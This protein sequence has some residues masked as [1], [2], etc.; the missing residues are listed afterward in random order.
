[1][2]QERITRRKLLASLGALGR[3][4]AL[5]AA[6]CG[7]SEEEIQKMVEAAVEATRTAPKNM[8]TAEANLA[9]LQA[10]QKTEPQPQAE[11]KITIPPSPIAETQETLTPQVLWIKEVKKSNRAG[12]TAFLMREGKVIS[13]ALNKNLT[14]YEISSGNQIWEWPNQVAMDYYKFFTDKFDPSI[15]YAENSR[16]VTTDSTVLF[17]LD[18]N[19]GKTKWTYELE[20]FAGKS[21]KWNLQYSI[22][23]GIVNVYTFKDSYEN[24]SFALD[25]KTSQLLWS[26][27]G[28]IKHADTQS[29]TAVIQSG[30]RSGQRSERL[31]VVDLYTGKEKLEIFNESNPGPK[32]Y[33][34][35]GYL[36]E[37][38]F[39]YT[40]VTLGK[41]ENDLLF[42]TDLRTGRRAWTVEKPSINTV[43]NVKGRSPERVYF[44]FNV[45]KGGKLI[46]TLTALD[47]KSGRQLW[48]F[49]L[50]EYSISNL[51]TVMGEVKN[52][53]IFSF[54]NPKATVCINALNGKLLWQDTNL[55]LD[56]IIGVFGNTLVVTSLERVNQENYNQGIH[57]LDLH[58]GKPKWHI[59][60]TSRSGSD[61]EVLLE[62]DKVF[63]SNDS[64]KDL[65]ISNA[66]TG[67]FIGRYS[68]SGKQ[69]RR[70]VSA[71]NGIV[72]VYE[73]Q[74]GEDGTLVAL[75]A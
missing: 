14:A 34:T 25:K 46:N 51:R 16:H 69:T 73:Y 52:T 43:L 57:G 36:S 20:G 2:W 32:P 56:K 18:A 66:Q 22:E 67:R 31:Y 39:W 9:N 24:R 5:A 10:Q 54:E 70:I 27:E 64:L 71:P 62:N 65:Q 33:Y 28:R 19:T 53:L 45:V 40:I 35:H 61:L 72:L 44:T 30:G 15:L 12:W 8:A 58:S 60:T 11:S 4:G 74:G 47:K 38:S 37:E 1:M 26:K 29:Q 49:E 63:Y 48:D 41:S 23:D 50:G 68:A 55:L 3:L 13:F 6:G 7:P 59:K 42:T 21:P 17:N 75:R